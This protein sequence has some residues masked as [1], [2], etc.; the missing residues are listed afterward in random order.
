[1]T[2][3]ICPHLAGL[4]IMTVQMVRMQIMQMKRRMLRRLHQ[5]IVRMQTRRLHLPIRPGHKMRPR[6]T[7]LHLR[8]LVMLRA[9]RRR[10]LGLVRTLR[11][12]RLKLPCLLLRRM[13]P[14]HCVHLP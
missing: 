8:R 3:Q 2:E 14:R 6:P 5:R 9:S 10:P 4:K 11:P 1:M 7:C 13:K 12:E